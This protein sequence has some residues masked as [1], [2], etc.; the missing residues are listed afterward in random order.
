MEKR[1]YIL[2]ALAVVNFSHIVDSMLIMPLGDIFIEQFNIDAGQYSLLVSSYAFAAFLSAILGIFYLDGFDR[3][4]ALVF[5]YSGFAIGTFLCAFANTYY[6][7]L[8]L[9]FFTGFFGGIIGA[10]VLS[11]VSDLYLFKERGRAMGVLMAAFS[12]ASAFGIPVGLYL[13]AKGSWQT[14][15]LF[16][17]A[18]GLV[19][20]GFV[21]WFFPKMIQ[22]MDSAV[23]RPSPIQSLKTIFVDANQINALIAGFV[24]ILGHFLIIPFIT[25]YLIK[26]VGLTQ[27]DITWQFFLGGVFTVI[28]SPIIGKLT[29]KFGVK[30]VFPV[31]MVLSFIPTLLITHLG[32]VSVYIALAYTT[33]FFITATGRMI[34]SNALISAAAP[35]G[36]RGSFMSFKS[37]LQQLG[38]A[39]ASLI[40]GF[41]VFID[42]DDGLFHNY[43]YVG[44]LAIAIC[45]SSLIMVNKLKVST[46][47]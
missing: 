36:N 25:P 11:I 34:P 7:L 33:L 24:I 39:L 5:V 45:A 40:S 21:A 43:Q 6:M 29:D 12:A 22:H 17:G 47:N 35:V 14:P 10:L 38:I 32:V 18:F 3:K 30:R 20:V 42:K 15:F 8:A 1:K 44:F 28:T 27:M 4:S 37:S 16:I 13:A 46:G 41:I 9:R 23:K 31:M 19:I 2:L 26:N